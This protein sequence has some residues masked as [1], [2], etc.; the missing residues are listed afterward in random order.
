METAFVRAV[1]RQTGIPAWVVVAAGIPV[2]FYGYYWIVHGQDPIQL[3]TYL[4]IMFRVRVLGQTVRGGT[5][6]PTQVVTNGR[7]NRNG[8]GGGNR[9]NGPRKYVDKGRVPPPK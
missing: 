7:G 3:T 9:R 1:Q 4:S 8:N 6:K 5:G 2:A